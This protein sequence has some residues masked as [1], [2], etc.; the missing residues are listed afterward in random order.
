MNNKSPTTAMAVASW[1]IKKGQD[2]NNYVDQMK[3]NKL[4]YYTFA[5]YAGNTGE[6]LF[7][8]EIEAWPH[9]P[10]V[11]ELYITFKG[12]GR[13]AI[14]GIENDILERD[15]KNVQNDQILELFTLI[16]EDFKDWTGTQMSHLSHK[17]TGPWAWVKKNNGGQLKENKQGR[18]P[19]IP[20][21]E[22]RSIFMC[23]VEKL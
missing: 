13:M 19:I 18:Y 17:D 8:E 15:I 5:W 6:F 7:D 9:G 12:F 11:N 20:K 3:L 2:T 4:V 21:E 23:E 10:V 14:S 22:I 16:W 1:F